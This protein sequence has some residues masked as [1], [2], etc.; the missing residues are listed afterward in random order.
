MGFCDVK[1]FVEDYVKVGP[2]SRVNNCCILKNI[3]VHK[4]KLYAGPRRCTETNPFLS[5]LGEALST[6]HV[7]INTHGLIKG[8]LNED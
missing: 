2:V 1:V 8:C 5:A 4:I 6:I 7:F 3:G